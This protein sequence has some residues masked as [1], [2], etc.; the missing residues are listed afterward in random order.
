[1][2]DIPGHSSDHRVLENLVCKPNNTTS[3]VNMWLI[4]FNQ[5][6]DHTLKIDLG[7]V[8]R[9]G[10]IKFFNYNKSP[11]D[12]LRGAKQIFISV[13]GVPVTDPKTGITL[14]KAPG[15]VP[16]SKGPHLKPD[17]GQEVVLPFSKGWTA[18][19]IAPLHQVKR[20]ESFMS[21]TGVRQEFEPTKMPVGFTFRFNLYSTHGDHFYVGL[22]GIELLDQFGEVITVEAKKHVWADPPGVSAVKGMEQDERTI[23]KLFDGVNETEDDNHMWLA[24][25]KFTRSRAAAQSSQQTSSLRVPNYVEVMFDSPVCLGAVR[26][27]N[28]QKT[29]SR[30]VHEFE[31]VVDDKQ[32]FRGFAAKAEGTNLSTAVVFNPRLCD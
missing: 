18:A 27:W 7:R 31:L 17:F 24:P 14:R 23:D 12:S 6:E 8:T 16:K 25:F 10:S 3:D 20:T 15:V 4:P 30:G 13:D 21:M 29:P 26:V 9:I 19:Q 1:M 11:E 22:N 28:Y 32:V 2:N 5:G